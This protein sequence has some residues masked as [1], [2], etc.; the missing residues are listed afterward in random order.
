M[1]YSLCTSI[2]FAGLYS[3]VLTHGSSQDL[4]SSKFHSANL[5]K[6]CWGGCRALWIPLVSS[7]SFL[8][9]VR[10][11]LC[12]ST[13]LPSS[14]LRPTLSPLLFSRSND[15][16]E[17]T[18]TLFS[19]PAASNT[20]SLENGENYPPPVTCLRS[21]TCIRDPRVRPPGRQFREGLMHL[22]R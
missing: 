3:S 19:L 20:S 21:D 17:T 2:H 15:C 6:I 12:M 5:T 7:L 13:I 16:L 10:G 4:L 22:F 14:H 11:H 1:G 18:H 9:V 8:A